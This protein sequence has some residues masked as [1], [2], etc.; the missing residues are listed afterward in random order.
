MT[1][2]KAFAILT[3]W[4][5][6]YHDEKGALVRERHIDDKYNEAIKVVS[7][8]LGKLMGVERQIKN[9]EYIAPFKFVR[10]VVA[11]NNYNT[12]KGDGLPRELH[13]GVFFLD[14]DNF[15]RAVESIHKEDLD[16]FFEELK[17]NK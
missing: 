6:E 5:H 4:F 8:A 15:P 9:G 11:Y 7:E 2:Q 10:P 12:A 16:R 3:D 13:Y 17:E 14:K 1:Y